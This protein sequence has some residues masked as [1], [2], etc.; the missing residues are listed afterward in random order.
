MKGFFVMVRL[1]NQLTILSIYAKMN[2]CISTISTRGK[3]V[4]LY[5]QS[6]FNRQAANLYG[7]GR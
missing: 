6:E 2:N 3:G 1:G 7:A 5:A 4:Y